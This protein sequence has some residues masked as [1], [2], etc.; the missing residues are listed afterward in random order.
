M[1][2]L[3]AGLPPWRL[4]G[5]RAT[6]WALL[7]GGWVG[8]GSLAQTLAAGPAAAFAVLALWLLA[9]GGCARLIGRL[10]PSALL[11]RG[12]LVLAA[13]LAAWAL[14]AALHGGGLAALL[15]VALAWA[16]LVALAS[17]AVRASRKAAR[18]TP[19]PPVGAAA[20]GAALAW[21]CLG[22]P[23][24]LSALGLRLMGGAFVACVMLAVLMPVRAGTVGGCGAG[25][26]DCSLPGWQPRDWREPRRCPVL[27][28]SLVMLPM[29]CGLPL[30]LSLCRSDAVPPQAVL[31]VHFA[32]M[33]VPALVAIGRPAI[34]AAAPGVCAALL[35][36]GAGALVL[37]PGPQAWWVLVLA[38]GAAWSMAWAA[39][40]GD[41]AWR[42]A[43]A[44]PLVGAMLNALFAWLLGLGI[45]A[46]GLQALAGW[47]LALGLVAAL[48]LMA[49][50][51]R[52]LRSH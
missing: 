35:A 6:A 17:S 24:D 45:A 25:L 19:R 16:L 22:D 33:F 3:E 5:A 29:M 4:Q 34:L 52:R 46:V 47:H 11:L 38:H 8:L 36:L 31:G 23:T 41:P 32:A 10:R 15:A 18:A 40:L 48:A 14:S 13:S 27:L 30:M 7:L 42:G 20:C 49:R 44:S 43:R 26:F 2:P 21:G 12:L 50:P 9:L 28:A 51:I 39:Q 1:T 37:M